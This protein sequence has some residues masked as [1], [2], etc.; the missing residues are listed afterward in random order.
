MRV[1][2]SLAALGVTSARCADRT[3]GAL[4]GAP[5]RTGC[6]DGDG[7]SRLTSP[8]SVSAT[9]STAS[10]P[11]RSCPGSRDG[12]RPGLRCRPPRD[13]ACHRPAGLRSSWSRCGA[14][15]RP[16]SS[17]SSRASGW[18]R[19]P[20]TRAASR[21][22][23]GRW[24]C[25]SPGVRARRARPGTAA[26]RLLGAGGMLDLLG[27]RHASIRTPI[28]RRASSRRFSRPRRLQGRGRS[29]S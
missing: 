15:A 12:V 19:S 25:V 26:E 21:P 17:E 22:S 10:G 27:R 28:S 29:L 4:R 1:G 18:T 16:S 3:P 14:I 11:C 20:S 2:L 8:A 23:E 9:S 6:P 13:T 7:R 24:M 5:G